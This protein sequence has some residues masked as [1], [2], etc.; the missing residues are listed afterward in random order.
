MAVTLYT[1]PIERAGNQR[2]PKYFRWRYDPDPPG[3]ACTW[4][5]MDYGFIDVALLAAIDIVPTDDTFLR[6]QSDIYAW[7]AVLTVAI[8]DRTQIDTFFEA[9]NIPT[10]WLTPA[11]TYLEFL[12]QMAGLFQ[13]NQRYAGLSGGASLLGG[14]ATLDT[15]WNSLT[16][17][18]QAWF[19]QTIASFGYTYSVTGNPRLRTLAKQVGDLWGAQPF[20]LGGIQF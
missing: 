10:D 9:I 5:M 14:T 19:N 20:Y 6:A 4:T 8:S 2:G 13:F 3:I 17:Q 18:Q 1:L 15:Q 7:S 11:N 16:A 12:R